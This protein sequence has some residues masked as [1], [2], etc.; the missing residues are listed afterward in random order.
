MYSLIILAGG[1]GERSGCDRPKQFAELGGVP[2]IG[3]TLRRGELMDEVDEVVISCH[4]AY[5]DEVRGYITEY[6]LKKPYK[7]ID[8]GAPRQESTYRAL[9][10]CS[11]DDCS[12]T[13]PPG[14]SPVWRFPPPMDAPAE[15]HSGTPVPFSVVEGGTRSKG[16]LDRPP[17]D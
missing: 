9:L 7:I 12:F 5:K 13:S 16:L 17:P 11:S 4:Q 2:M 6:A 14:P 1:V 10:A 8:G 15:R 3:H